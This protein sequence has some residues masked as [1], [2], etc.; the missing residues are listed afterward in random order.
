MDGTPRRSP[1]AVAGFALSLLLGL[2][3]AGEALWRIAGHVRDGFERRV[4]DWMSPRHVVAVFGLP[5]AA[6][7]PILK[8]APGALPFASIRDLALASGRS[9]EAVTAEV[10]AQ[11][12]ALGDG[13]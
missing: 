3:F 8:I 1:L 13:P 11:V 2:G 9:P 7:A 10:Q 4:E 12:D 6:L 5:E